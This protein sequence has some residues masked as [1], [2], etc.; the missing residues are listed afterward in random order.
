MFNPASGQPIG[1][2]DWNADAEAREAIAAAN[3]AWAGW[4]NT[5]AADR[6][7]LLHHW[8]ELLASNAS[9]IHKIMTMES[10]K[11]LK[12]AAGEMQAGLASLDWF[13]GEA[14]R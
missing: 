11:P 6:A 10:G 7:K 14:T 12:E 8:R 4:R 2:V 5:T 13:A 3:T 9:D 1:A